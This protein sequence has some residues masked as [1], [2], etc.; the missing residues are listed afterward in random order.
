M[1][2]GRDR[3]HPIELEDGVSDPD[4]EV[5]TPR[6][7]RH[8]KDSVA[9]RAPPTRED[10]LKEPQPTLRATS[11]LTRESHLLDENSP[12]SKHR[13][14]H[15]ERRTSRERRRSKH[16]D[17]APEPYEPMHAHVPA[18]GQA[19]I[20][21]L[22][23]QP[24]RPGDPTNVPDA[25]LDPPYRPPP[26]HLPDL[27]LGEDPELDE[28]F[29]GNYIANEPLGQFADQGILEQEA[30]EQEARDQW[31]ELFVAEE[32][33][34]NHHFPREYLP[35][36]NAPVVKDEGTNERVPLDSTPSTND[37]VVYIREVAV[38]V[39]DQ[40]QEDSCLAKILEVFPDIS[41]DHVRTIYQERRMQDFKY[42]AIK[43][44]RAHYD[45]SEVLIQEIIEKPYPKQ[46]D[47]KRKRPVSSNVSQED[48]EKWGVDD[49]PRD[50]VYLDAAYVP[51]ILH[52]N[53]RYQ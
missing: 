35:F 26:Y 41:Q 17:P 34:F 31:N 44:D 36:G 51:L 1:N 52:S 39:D 9:K 50:K 3:D 14:R 24:E 47:T 11:P 19:A 40:L 22:N 15:R 42:S 48:D 16:H 20:L 45:P 8:A 7:R 49:G 38:S 23:P 2:S 29:W 4:I 33:N 10:A 32:E 25:V 12:G 5:Y 37:D 6:H 53:S 27:G 28:Q 43:D 18:A 30:L 21:P 13:K 46:R